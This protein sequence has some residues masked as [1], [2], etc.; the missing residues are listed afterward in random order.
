MQILLSIVLDLSD[1]NKTNYDE[2]D[3]HIEK[4]KSQKEEITEAFAYIQD[5][6]RLFT[7]I[8]EKL[9]FN[10][11]SYPNPHTIIAR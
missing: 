4:L 3:E 6:D 2:I 9:L 7:Q 8:K 11:L 1:F 10:K 5:C